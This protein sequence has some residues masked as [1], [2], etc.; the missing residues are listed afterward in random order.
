[1]IKYCIGVDIL[2]YPVYVTHII[3]EIEIVSKFAE[4][5]IKEQK[6]DLKVKHYHMQHK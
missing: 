1:M 3:P 5:K 6:Q 2:N 4:S